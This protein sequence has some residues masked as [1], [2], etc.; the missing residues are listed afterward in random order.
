MS[1]PYK[2]FETQHLPR[3]VK[4]ASLIAIGVVY[5]A[6][7]EDAAAWDE[8]VRG[9]GQAYNGGYYDGMPCGREPGRDFADEEHGKLYAVTTA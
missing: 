5:L 4:T 1:Y 9:T 8:H 6:S 3:P 2:R 7:E